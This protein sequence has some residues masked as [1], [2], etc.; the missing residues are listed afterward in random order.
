[1]KIWKIYKIHINPI[2]F[3]RLNLPINAIFSVPKHYKH[4]IIHTIVYIK[5]YISNIINFYCFTLY[6]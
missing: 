4:N 5:V 6:F 3:T 1:M 2:N